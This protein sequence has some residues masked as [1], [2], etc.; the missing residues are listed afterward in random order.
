M[1][2]SSLSTSLAGIQSAVKRMEESAGRIAQY[3][4]GGEYSPEGSK[5]ID[6]A[7]ESV[8]LMLGKTEVKVNIRAA[9]LVIEHE[10]SILD[11]KT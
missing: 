7:Q 9:E 6:L 3:G 4:N 1:P 11:I 10:N 8:K 2:I 5:N